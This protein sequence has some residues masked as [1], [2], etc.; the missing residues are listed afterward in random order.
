M[1]QINAKGEIR[2]VRKQHT[3]KMSR[4]RDTAVHF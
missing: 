4:E 2:P 1:L 3:I